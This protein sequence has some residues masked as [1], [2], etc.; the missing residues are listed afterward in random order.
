MSEPYADIQVVGRVPGHHSITVM[1]GL[2]P[3]AEAV[4][5]QA[6]A[7]GLPSWREDAQEEAESSSVYRR[8][9]TLNDQIRKQ[10]DRVD[11]AEMSRRHTQAAKTL[12]ET[13]PGTEF[14]DK[15]RG[16]IAKLDA[17]EKEEA[18]AKQDLR[19]I[20]PHSSRPWVDAAN[21]VRWSVPRAVHSRIDELDKQ[22]KAARAK[23]DEGCKKVAAAIVKAIS[24]HLTSE[25]T[26]LSI[27]EV[28][29]DRARS[30]VAPLTAEIF[31][32]LMGTTLAE[33]PEGI[34]FDGQKFFVEPVSQ[35]SVET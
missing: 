7:I 15:L 4:A 35:M 30:G 22:L 31:R 27:L 16:V 10:Q 18:A 25:V 23:V 20:L 1:A 3:R 9:K 29:I 12:L 6:D 8:F 5:K 17:A 14:A 13:N 11:R 26:E 19:L 32:H 2:P 21:A 24:D 28:A 34:A 33:P